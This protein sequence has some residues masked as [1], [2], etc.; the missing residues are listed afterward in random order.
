MA[1]ASE[2]MTDNSDHFCPCMI[3]E[4]NENNED[5][6]WIFCE[7]C[8]T[9]FHSFCALLSDTEYDEIV[10]KRAKWF[11]S[12]YQCQEKMTTDFEDVPHIQTEIQNSIQVDVMSQLTKPSQDC[13]KCLKC[14]FIAKNKR[15]L[16]IH[17][18][19]KHVENIV[20]F[21]SID[22]ENQSTLHSEINTISEHLDTKCDIC[23]Q[24]CKGYR[25]LAVHKA[26][27]H[28]TEQRK[29]ITESYQ[30]NHQSGEDNTDSSNLNI[31]LQDDQ[32]ESELQIFWNKMKN[33]FDDLIMSEEFLIEKCDYLVNELIMKLREIQ[34]VLPGPKNPNTKYYEMRKNK[35]FNNTDR[36][37][38]EN[39]IRNVIEKDESKNINGIGS[40]GYT[41]IK[42]RE[43]FVSF[44]KIK[45]TLA[46]LINS[47]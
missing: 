19:K 33:E 35:N 32:S 45:I 27:K 2:D 9:W 47:T 5:S 25:G 38:K 10:K 34:K 39:T 6:K 23:D 43:Q 7:G 14:S 16:K 22:I 28:K 24:F 29:K 18:S 46:Q 42:G 26:K 13:E 15:G 37:Y 8:Q 36:K 31:V 17:M 1:K 20:E 41:T 12:F 3:G 4:I 21:T 30:K 11:C 44:L 40:N